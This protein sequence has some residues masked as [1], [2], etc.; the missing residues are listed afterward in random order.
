VRSV[1]A[2][3]AGPVVLVGHSY[4]GAVISNAAVGMSD[5]KALVYIAAFI[6]DEG[7][8]IGS[9][10]S[11]TPGTLLGPDTTWSVPF[12]DAS[13]PGGANTDV[14]ID[15]DHFAEVFAADVRGDLVADLAATQRPL[16]ATA[17]DGVSGPP[18]WRTI[19]SWALITLED[20]A[21]PPTAQKA[22]AARAE[23]YVE[24]VHSSHAVMVAHPQAV[25]NIV[26]DAAQRT[27]TF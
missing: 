4:G 23:S 11:E 10:L 18:A 9:I 6:P 12:E 15:P 16:A 7:E 25:V 1:L 2:G 17:Q 24:T 5:V 13:A 19:P 3:I 26:Q 20:K 21:V 22:M 27:F 8:S 14:F